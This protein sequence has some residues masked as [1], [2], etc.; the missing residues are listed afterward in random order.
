[1]LSTRLID[2]TS[3]SGCLSA[4]RW[5]AQRPPGR[6]GLSLVRKGRSRSEDAAVSWYRWAGRW[7]V[8]R[9]SD[10]RGYYRP[11]QL[12]APPPGS[13]ESPIVSMNS[14]KAKELAD[15]ASIFQDL[16]RVEEVLKR[17]EKVAGSHDDTVLTEALWSAALVWWCRSFSLGRRQA[18][19]LGEDRLDEVGPGANDFHAFLKNMRDKHIS[20]SVNPFEKVSVG[21]MLSPEGT[22]PRKVE[23]VATLTSRHIGLELSDI[24]QFLSLAHRLI[25]I[26]AAD[27]KRLEGE[28]RV[29]AQEMPLEDLARGQRLRITA[30]GPIEAGS[31]RT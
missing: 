11:M 24:R 3:G 15:A 17:L 19:R 31:A 10:A 27:C 5:V 14:P 1:M 16:R 20:H 18:Y 12:P 29:E 6:T 30:P 9:V 26:V 21:V 28:L 7:G 4:G 13:T 2:R 23:G 22:E 25:E 8:A